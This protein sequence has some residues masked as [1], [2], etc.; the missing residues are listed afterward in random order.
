MMCFNQRGFPNCLPKSMNQ[1]ISKLVKL[2]CACA[3][4]GGAAHAQ[5]AKIGVGDAVKLSVRGVPDQQSVMLNGVYKVDQS[6]LLVGLPFL[7]R[8]IQAAGLTEGQLSQLIAYAYREADIYTRATFTA[9]VDAP[10]ENRR[11]MVAG[12]AARQGPLNYV[13][14]MTIFDAFSTAGGADKFG[15]KKRVYLLREGQ[16]KGP[17]NMEN[18]ADKQVLLLPNDTIEVDTKKWNEP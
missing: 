9:M 13:A 5:V 12:K 1:I 16:R 2:A 18:D 8:N 15:Q 17:Y 11:I 14:N 3:L 7:E 6:G 10:P 4:L